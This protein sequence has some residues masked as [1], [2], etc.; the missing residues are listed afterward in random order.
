[1]AKKKL[2][3]NV[4]SNADKVI[5]AA[6]KRWYTY[7]W[8]WLSCLGD[9]KFSYETMFSIQK[10]NPEAQAAKDLIARMIGR[11]WIKFIKWDLLYDDAK[12]EALLLNT[13]KDA[14]TWSWKTFKDKYYTNYF[15]SWMVNAYYATM[16]DGS[17]R[18]QV[19]DSRY[20]H[21]DFDKYG[22]ITQMTFNGEELSKSDTISQI[23]KYDPDRPGYWLS[24]YNTVV[25]DA[26]ADH[27][28]AKRNY[29][30]FRNWA[31]PSV[32]LTME[33]DIENEDEINAAIDQFEQKYQWTEKSHGI[34]ALW[35]V[36]EIRTLDISNRDLE[37]LDLRKFSIKV[38]G[39]LFWFDPRFLAFR[40]WENG[41]HSEY[42]QLAVK[43]D[44]TM[45]TYADVLE[46]FMLSVT[47][48]LY[49][50]FPYDNIELIND[51]FLDEVTKIDMYKSE[52]Q[53]W[54]ST[55]AEI[56]KRLWKPTNELSE[57]MYKYYMNVQFN[58][59]DWIVAES[60]ARVK[61]T[62]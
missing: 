42:A 49:P 59:I 33:D 40:D 5:S 52:I 60:E 10:K 50:E 28:S 30:F 37:L 3:N 6:K 48:D 16:G 4:S 21:K 62:E 1:M 12:W 57:N 27:E 53:N 41:S 11:N 25:Y 35:W 34:L 36:K 2:D 26:L 61:P 46:E 54:I 29:M 31:I 15:C 14:N 58:T 7:V 55:P 22:N 19:L 47:K 45:S 56:I 13:F 39:M 20:V 51:T 44:K 18:V 8:G 24:I 9:I 23:V 17:R 32:I 43:S 38:F